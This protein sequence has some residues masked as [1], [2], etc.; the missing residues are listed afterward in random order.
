MF[1]VDRKGGVHEAL[2][3]LFQRGR[4]PPKMIVDGSKEQNLGDFK[5]KVAEAG[6]HL[7]HAEPESPYQIAAERIIRELKIWS[8][9]NMTK[10][11][12]YLN[13]LIVT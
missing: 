1:T 8:G 11:R 10:M 9:R 5:S 7:R 12:H 6:C 3:L 13:I 4:V 2:S